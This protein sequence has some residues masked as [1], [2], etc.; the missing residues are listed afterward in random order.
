MQALLAAKVSAIRRTLATRQRLPGYVDL[1]I[2]H[3]LPQ[4]YRAHAKYRE[5]TYGICDDCDAAIPETRLSAAP[6]AT[7]CLH[8]Q[9]IAE[10][11][12]A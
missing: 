7:R 5:G 4:L 8:C 9:A 11:R 12:S 3:V 1:K 6:G 10:R 2:G